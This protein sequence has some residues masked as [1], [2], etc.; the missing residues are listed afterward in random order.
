MDAG[1]W[2]R[3]KR[4]RGFDWSVTNPSTAPS[5]R[6]EPHTARRVY[7]E[8]GTSR[9]RAPASGFT[10]YVAVQSADYVMESGG[11]GNKTLI[12]RR[13]CSCSLISNPKKR[14]I[15]PTCVS[16]TI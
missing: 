13:L 12:A 10:D 1:D 9:I 3:L 6:L 2:I 7:T 5:L 4:I 16:G 15:C 11:P 14:G 8:F